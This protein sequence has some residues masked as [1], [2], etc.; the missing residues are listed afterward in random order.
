MCVCVCV[1]VCVPALTGV[2]KLIGHHPANQKVMHGFDSWLGHIPRLWVCSLVRV[3]MKDNWLMFLSYISPSLLLS[4]KSV[5]IFSD[6]DLENNLKGNVLKI[7]FVNNDL[8]FL[9][10]EVSL[11]ILLEGASLG[12]WGLCFQMP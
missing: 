3:Y 2:A 12:G 1:C 6:E 9:G 4:L 5:S 11:D 7:P 10:M 8:T